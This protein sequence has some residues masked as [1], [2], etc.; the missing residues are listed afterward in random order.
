MLAACSMRSDVAVGTGSSDWLSVT[1]SP[2]PTTTASPC[3]SA[4]IPASFRSPTRTSF[5]HFRLAWHAGLLAHRA[6]H[7]D[8][9]EQG[10]PAPP[11]RRHIGRPEQHGKDEAGPWWGRPGPAQPTPPGRLLLGH[12]DEPF[13][14]P[15]PGG[16]EQVGVGGPGL[17]Q[18]GDF[19][20]QTA[21]RDEAFPQF[22]GGQRR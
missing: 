13:G 4:R 8:P 17:P 6:G 16:I 5:G 19:P 22:P 20:P 11:G 9:G 15:R 7:G 2:T 3:A 18:H 14:A 10:Q 12:Q 21:R 1:F